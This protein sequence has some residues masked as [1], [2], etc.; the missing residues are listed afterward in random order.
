MNA[1]SEAVNSSATNIPA[2]MALLA[3][4]T[5]RCPLKCPYCSN[6]TELVRRSAELSTQEWLDVIN[7]AA[8]MGVLHV[9]LSGG[10]PAAR[11]DLP[12]LV[13]GVAR[14]GLYSNLITS[15]VSLK[16]P[17][18]TA[19]VEAGLDHVQ[20]SVQGADVDRADWIGGYKGG[21]ETKMAVA[22]WIAEAGLPLTINA[23]MHRQNLEQL[24]EV[25]AL[26]RRLKARRLEVAHTQYHGWAL[27]NRNMLMPTPEQVEQARDVVATARDEMAAGEMVIDYVPPDHYATFPKAC[28][29]G[30]GRFGLNVTPEGKVLPCHAAESIS[31]LEFDS[32]RDRNLAEIWQD[33]AAFNAFRGVEWMPEPCRGCERQTVDWGGCRCQ[34]MA[35]V[36]DAKATDPACSRS[37]HHARFQVG[38]V[39]FSRTD[40][41]RFIYRG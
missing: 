31:G 35:F 34:A 10:E 38:A 18:F 19:C 37:P 40:G 14:T 7:Q 15:G 29:G 28:M 4:L 25:I 12:D 21:Y 26:A 13:A 6:P 17:M 3:E 41:S 1:P 9:H 39:E 24:P 32:V 11:R 5:H 36:G 2:P 30:W 27:L 22:G 8:D 20:L 33:G 23:V 16:K